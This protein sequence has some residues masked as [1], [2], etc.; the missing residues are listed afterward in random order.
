MTFLE[1]EALMKI[2]KS[3]LKNKNKNYCEL[4][5]RLQTCHKK[6]LFQPYVSVIE[7]LYVGKAQCCLN[8][9]LIV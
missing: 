1:G 7:L 8:I 4:F 6:D 5:S 3:L 2:S 9:L